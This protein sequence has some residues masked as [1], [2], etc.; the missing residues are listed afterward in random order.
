MI[1]NIDTLQIISIVLTIN[2]FNT[3]KVNW[4]KIPNK[5]TLKME[6]WNREGRERIPVV[7]LVGKE[8][9]SCGFPVR[10]RWRFVS[11]RVNIAMSSKRMNGVVYEFLGSE[12]LGSEERTW[13][14]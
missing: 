11:E 13:W 9:V 8:M 2:Q 7:V 14:R 5:K 1:Y 12:C 3:V 4:K 6:I 10:E